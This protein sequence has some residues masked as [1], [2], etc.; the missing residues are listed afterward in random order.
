MVSICSFFCGFFKPKQLLKLKTICI[1]FTSFT[2]TAPSPWRQVQDRLT[3]SL[4][5]LS[6][7]PAQLWLQADGKKLIKSSI[8]HNVN[9]LHDHTIMECSVSNEKD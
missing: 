7:L 9:E 8:H 6:K 5:F 2:I 3:P 1:I 4:K